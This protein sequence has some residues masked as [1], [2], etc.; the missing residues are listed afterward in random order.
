MAGLFDPV[1]DHELDPMGAPLDLLQPAAKP[2]GSKWKDLA[3]LLAILPL[4]LKQGGRVGGAAL[5]QG[6][7]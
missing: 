5:L 2:G 3:P 4:A 1:N 7:Q 6:F